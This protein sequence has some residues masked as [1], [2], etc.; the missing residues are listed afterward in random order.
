MSRYRG[1]RIRVVRR[2]G[3][4]PGLTRRQ[5]KRT[6]PPG[7]HGA[8]RQKQSQYDIRLR[9]KQKLRYHYGLTERQ[10]LT[11]VRRARNSQGATGS[12]LLATLE[13]RLDNIVYR[14]GFAPTIR[15]SRQ[16]VTHGHIC[17]NGQQVD[18][19]SFECKIGDIISIANKTQ[20]QKLVETA[21]SQN[22]RPI[23]PFLSI[24]SDGKSGRVLQNC[25]LKDIGLQAR[26]QLS[27]EHYSRRA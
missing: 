14:L 17:V 24:Q 10:L 5:A 23:P 6:N 25:S 3:E 11:L 18:I 15:A 21:L 2:L 12:Y 4:L 19:N 20:S 16:L 7:E 8:D 26:P 9:E 27:I 1:P 13:R 22:N